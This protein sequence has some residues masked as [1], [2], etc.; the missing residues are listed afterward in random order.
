[1]AF[2]INNTSIQTQKDNHLEI[3]QSDFGGVCVFGGWETDGRKKKKEALLVL[4]Y[5]D[6][7][8]G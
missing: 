2:F 5:D 4:I 1:M 8:S 3:S 6:V 7:E